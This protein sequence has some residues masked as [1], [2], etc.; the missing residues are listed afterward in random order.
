MNVQVLNNAMEV[1]KSDLGDGLMASDIW[2]KGTGQPI[3]G[4]QGSLKAVAL[5][6]QIIMNIDKALKVSEYPKMSNYFMIRLKGN[7]HFI[8]VLVDNLEWKMAVD[9]NKVPL[10]LLLNIALP[11]AIAEIKKK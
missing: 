11:N 6:D 9:G 3:V 10:G 4:Y 7:V 1:L 5:F 8:V 2:I